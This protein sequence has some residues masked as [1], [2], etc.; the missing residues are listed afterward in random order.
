MFG[1]CAPTSDRDFELT[2]FVSHFATTDKKSNINYGNR[3]TD[4]EAFDKYKKKQ[5]TFR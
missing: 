3:A 5:Q 4:A 2:L 1:A